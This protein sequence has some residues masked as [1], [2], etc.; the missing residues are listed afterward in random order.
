MKKVLLV[1]DS[2][3]QAA[4]TQLGLETR[5][6]VVEVAYNGYSALSKVKEWSP[7]IIVLDYCLPDIDGVEICRRI[8]QNPLHRTIPIVVFSAE[9]TLRNMTQAYSA[10]A[11]SYVVK[12]SEGESVLGLLIES[13]VTRR[14]RFQ[15]LDSY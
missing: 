8:K 10:G 15:R 14:N 9:D 12:E 7:D 2:I 6:F 1:E 5:G 11:D 4:K 3:T 13:I